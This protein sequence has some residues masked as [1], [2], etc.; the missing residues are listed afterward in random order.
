MDFLEGR[1]GDIAD[2]FDEFECEPNKLHFLV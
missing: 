2:S 1:E